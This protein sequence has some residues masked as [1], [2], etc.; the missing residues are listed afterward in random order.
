MDHHI[1]IA[2]R[3]WSDEFQHFSQV[4]AS[5][6]ASDASFFSKR[7]KAF[8]RIFCRKVDK[9][10]YWQRH[11]YLMPCSKHLHFHQA[12]PIE[13]G[14]TGIVNQD[15]NQEVCNYLPVCELDLKIEA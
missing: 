10:V 12:K 9:V 1:L 7:K 4:A 8:K 14:A 13:S 15:E 5:D 11:C 3:T 6:S 2:T